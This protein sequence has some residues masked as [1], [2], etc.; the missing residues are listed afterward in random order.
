MSI[1]TNSNEIVKKPLLNVEELALL[2]ETICKGATDLEF[3]L[4]AG[5]CE[6]T[7]L[8]PF[9]GQIHAVKR[10]DAKLQR[11][12]MTIQTGINGFRLIAERTGDYE[13]Q[14]TP[15]WCGSDGIWKDVW[16]SSD[17]PIASRVGVWRKGFKEPCYGVAKFESYKQTYKDKATQE[18]KLS[19]M[20]SKM[21]DLMIA[22][23]A[24]A[25]AL[26]KAFPQELSGLYANEEMDQAEEAHG[27]VKTDRVVEI[28]DGQR[29]LT[30]QPQEVGI[31]QNHPPIESQKAP[32]LASEDIDWDKED[33]EKRS[34]LMEF[35]DKNEI[36]EKFL[37]E[38]IFNAKMINEEQKKLG[39]IGIPIMEVNKLLKPTLQNRMIELCQKSKKK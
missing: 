21:P 3:K 15:Y 23:V 20:W 9:A 34:Q 35:M 5:Q 1:N 36:S 6:R 33:A 24:E 2:K 11:E 7:R 13:G 38:T 28:V 16:V 25:Q 17:L 18:L 4:F 37:I 27:H 10:W 39:F 8:D 14:T 12:T 31:V 26:R 22:K 19:P 30:R 29:V 32:D